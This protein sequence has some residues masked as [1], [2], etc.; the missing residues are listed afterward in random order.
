METIIT[1]EPFGVTG[2]GEEVTRWTLRNAAGMEVRILSYGCTVQSIF[3]PDRKGKPIDVALGYDD[4]A[5]YEN[6]TCFFGAFIGRYANRIKHAA[7]E[8]NGR[9]Y[10]LEKNDGENL[11]AVHKAVIPN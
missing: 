8:L 11:L 9:L 6:G 5:G 1:S 10:T 3:V 4:L 7:F 2:A